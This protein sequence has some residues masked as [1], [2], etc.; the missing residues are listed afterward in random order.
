MIRVALVAVCL[1][2][3][4]FSSRIVDAQEP[5]PKIGPFVADLH[6]TIPR[7]TDNALVAASRELQPTELPGHGLGIDVGAHVYPLRI[8][9]VTIGIG[10]AATVSRGRKSADATLGTRAVEERFTSIGPQLSLNFT[11]RTGWSYLSGGIARSTWYIVPEGSAPFSADTER[12]RSFNFGGGARWFA[13]SHLAF[14]LDV[15]FHMIPAGGQFAADTTPQTLLFFVGAG[16][17]VK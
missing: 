8:G 13:K 10:A 3:S 14:S 1:T 9:P 17:S 7:F 16:I 4:L 6:L 2:C 5:V 15:R 12:I 11:G